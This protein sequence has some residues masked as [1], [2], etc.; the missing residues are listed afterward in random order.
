MEA[1]ALENVRKY[2]Y[3]GEKLINKDTKT[4]IDNVSFKIGKGQ[5]VAIIGPNGCGKTT[6]LKTIATIYMPDEGTIRVFD[7]DIFQNT[8]RARSAFSFVSPAL[9]FQNKLTL[10]QTLR[11]FGTVLKK[12]PEY[13]LPFLKRMGIMHMLD[14]R[15]EGFSEGQKAMVRLAIGLIKDPK[16]LL[17]DEVMANLDME[18]KERVL[19]FIQEQ[20]E[21]R[22]LTILMIDH[23]PHIV[24]RLCE[25]IIILREGGSLYKVTTVKDLLKAMDY[26]FEVD[27][28][29][30]QDMG[31]KQIMNISPTF[32][33]YG[34]KIRFFAH[35][36]GEVEDITKEILKRKDYV[37]Q[38]ATS[39][40]SLKDVYYLMMEGELGKF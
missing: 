16:I 34:N 36:E 3:V 5:N 38:F 14:K 22:D 28:T 32:R 23:D 33:R 21:L 15:L 39:E 26:Q 2:F 12:R 29:L 17:L 13:I 40:V 9:S 31:E 4:V 1:V 25:K 19:D 7:Q 37:L 35:G 6:M 10:E 24:D 8:E 11:F 18:R 27:V 20:D 30:K